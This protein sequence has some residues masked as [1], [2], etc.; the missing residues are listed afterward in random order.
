MARQGPVPGTADRRARALAAND[1]AAKKRVAAFIHARGFDAEDAGDRASGCAFESGTDVFN[2][3][4]NAAELSVKL[5]TGCGAAP[6]L[7]KLPHWLATGGNAG[8]SASADQLGPTSTSGIIGGVLHRL[9]PLPSSTAAPGQGR[10]A[11]R[12]PQSSPFEYWASWR[13]PKRRRRNASSRAG[14]RAHRL[15]AR[16]PSYSLH[17][18]RMDLCGISQEL[19]LESITLLATAASRA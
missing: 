6:G 18:L 15:P 10:D 13:R 16:T 5:N 11:Q 8:S 17:F 7:R 19:L 14:C 3:R 9:A 12:N 2:G 4:S 1:A